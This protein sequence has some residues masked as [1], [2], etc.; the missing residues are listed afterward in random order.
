MMLCTAAFAVDPRFQIVPMADMSAMPTLT[1]AQAVQ[2]FT[3]VYSLPSSA[4]LAD[5]RMPISA[6][7]AVQ[8]PAYWAEIEAELIAKGI[9]VAF[10]PVLLGSPLSSPLDAVSMGTGDWGTATA[11][12]SLNP[13][14]YMAA[15]LT[16]QFRPKDSKLWEASNTQTFRN[17]WAMAIAGGHPFA[18]IITWSDFSETGQ[19]Q[20]YT[21]ATLNPNIGTTF[22]NLTAYY[23]TWFVTGKQP[24]ITQ[25]TLYCCYRKMQ[26]TAAHLNQ[27]NA[28]VFDPSA[29]EESNIELLAF[30]TAPGT[31][32]I[33]GQAQ[34]APA[35]ITSFKVPTTPGTPSF[36]LRRNV[37]TFQG[38]VP[39]YGPQ[40]SP[41]QVLDLTYWGSSGNGLT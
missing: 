13:A 27:A 37:I 15:I 23:I 24:A 19:V 31:L 10:I 20:P 11:A 34:D 26:S 7:N 12:S 18:Q 40:G 17:C 32:V 6:F 33:N 36:A 30:L 41:A 25:D 38:P 4:R 5:G 16:Q 21:D 29:V 2:L 39:I 1:T 28:F 35:G 3:S 8:T 22:Y 14:S 9:G